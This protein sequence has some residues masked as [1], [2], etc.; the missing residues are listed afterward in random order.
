MSVHLLKTSSPHTL[1]YIV[2]RR[3][4]GFT[5]SCME[6]LTRTRVGSFLLE[7]DSLSWTDREALAGPDRWRTPYSGEVEGGAVLSGHPRK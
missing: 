4:A 3:A 5:G 7:E 1:C 6:Q 2:S